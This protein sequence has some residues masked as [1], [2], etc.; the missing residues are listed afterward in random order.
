MLY[1]TRTIAFFIGEVYF[2]IVKWVKGKAKKET[3]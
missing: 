2:A 3:L 1:Y